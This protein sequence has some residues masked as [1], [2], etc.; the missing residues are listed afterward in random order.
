MNIY[1]G[2][3]IELDSSEGTASENF[4]IFRHYYYSKICNLIHCKN[5]DRDYITQFVEP[6]FKCVNV[7]TDN[8]GFVKICFER[9]FQQ[10]QEPVQQEVKRGR[11]R[12]R[13]DSYPQ[14][15]EQ[16]DTNK[17][18][19]GKLEQQEEIQTY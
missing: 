6:D 8:S 15:T 13:K 10:V 12:P 3:E 19:E 7:E 2:M 17:Y 11:G 1:N 14:Q 18:V 4:K 16:E 9:V 5:W